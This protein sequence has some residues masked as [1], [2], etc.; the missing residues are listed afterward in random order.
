MLVFVRYEYSEFDERRFDAVLFQLANVLIE[1]FNF[2][3][4]PIIR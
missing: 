3:E 4:T 1:I 2:V